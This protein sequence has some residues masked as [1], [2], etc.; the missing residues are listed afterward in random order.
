MPARKALAQWRIVPDTIIIVLGELPCRTGEQGN[1]ETQ[2]A[3]RAGFQQQGRQD[4]AA[5]GGGLRMGV[6]QPAMQRHDLDA[7][8]RLGRVPPGVPAGKVE[9]SN[10]DSSRLEPLLVGGDPDG[11]VWS[12]RLCCLTSER[13]GDPYGFTP[14]ASADSAQTS[15]YGRAVRMDGPCDFGELSRAAFCR[16]AFSMSPCGELVEPSAIVPSESD[17]QWHGPKEK[18]HTGMRPRMALVLCLRAGDQPVRRASWLSGLNPQGEYIA[19]KRFRPI[20]RKS[21]RIWYETRREAVQGRTITFIHSLAG[22]LEDGIVAQPVPYGRELLFS[23]VSH[24]FFDEQHCPVYGH[25]LR[26]S[27]FEPI[28]ASPNLICR[29]PGDV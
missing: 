15:P 10:R 23:N 5:C 3:V 1:D 12:G 25:F 22:S 7:A 18:G 2:Q 20:P 11:H 24:D 8:E 21:L 13:G 9:V 26:R 6:A 28:K 14:S 19:S 17:N 27:T 16:I 29:F 4:H